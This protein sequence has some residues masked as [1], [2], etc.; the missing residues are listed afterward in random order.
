M[1]AFANRSTGDVI[2]FGLDESSDF[3]IVGVGNAHKLE[4]DITHMP[5][6]LMETT[7]RPEFM[8]DEVE[9]ETV[10][11]ELKR[12]NLRITCLVLRDDRVFNQEGLSCVSI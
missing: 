10:V 1:S 8:V 3:S 9:D 4:E 6:E 12:K 7:L 2:L 11:V 5:Y